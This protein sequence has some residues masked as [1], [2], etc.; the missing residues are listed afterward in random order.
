[1]KKLLL[2]GSLA[3]GLCQAQAVEWLAWT[4]EGAEQEFN[5]AMLV[6]YKDGEKLMTEDGWKTHVR[7]P[8]KDIEQIAYPDATGH[9]TESAKYYA[10]ISS[11]QG[12]AYS[13][14]LE[15]LNESWDVLNPEAPIVSYEA[16]STARFDNELG[17]PENQTWNAIGPAPVPE[18][19][20]G[21]LALLGL[22]LL[23]LK[24]K[25]FKTVDAMT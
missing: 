25:R 9:S 13:F 24:R 5:Y 10:D 21:T 18:P 20:G 1:M 15:L 7:E 22:A 6:V 8:G 11:W 19:T 17:I 4:V 2:A 23:G 3:M 12:A 14:Q 16:L